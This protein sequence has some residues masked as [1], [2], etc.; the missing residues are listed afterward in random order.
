MK[1]VY[2]MV[3]KVFGGERRSSGTIGRAGDQC[4]REHGNV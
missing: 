1:E 2:E 3:R 4:D